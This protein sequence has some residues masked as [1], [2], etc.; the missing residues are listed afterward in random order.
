MTTITGRKTHDLQKGGIKMVSSR[1]QTFKGLVGWALQAARCLGFT[2]RG[3]SFGREKFVTTVSSYAG[4]KVLAM[5]G[6]R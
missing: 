1:G 4:L 2:V 6:Q 5:R 3:C